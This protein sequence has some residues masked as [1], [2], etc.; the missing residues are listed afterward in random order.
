M[1]AVICLLAVALVVC[2]TGQQV[3]P[4]TCQHA[5]DC[6]ETVCHTEHGWFLHCAKGYCFCSHDTYTG[7]NCTDGSVATC[8][9]TH[10]TRCQDNGLRWHC[11]DG[12]CHCARI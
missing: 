7:K 2:V 10:G 9:A 5:A 1:K 8:I 6:R 3:G 11:L 12:V 4:E